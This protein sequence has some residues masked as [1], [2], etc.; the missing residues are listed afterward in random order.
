[1]IHLMNHQKVRF[2]RKKSK[3]KLITTILFLKRR[4]ENKSTYSLPKLLPTDLQGLSKNHLT[5]FF[6]KLDLIERRERREKREMTQG[7]L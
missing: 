3:N 7:K 1:M 5:G 6:I 4:H 2:W